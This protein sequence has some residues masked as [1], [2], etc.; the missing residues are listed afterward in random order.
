MASLFSASYFYYGFY[1]TGKGLF[2]CGK[3]RGV[4]GA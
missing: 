2:C 4:G 1:F 3:T